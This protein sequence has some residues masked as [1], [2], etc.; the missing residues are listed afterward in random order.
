VVAFLRW[1]I[2]AFDFLS[3]GR[4]KLTGW[5]SLPLMEEWWGTFDMMIW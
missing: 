1:L 2:D 5:F 3:L 4:S